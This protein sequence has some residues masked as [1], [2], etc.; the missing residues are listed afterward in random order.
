MDKQ[1]FNEG[2]KLLK[3]FLKDEGL[4]KPIYKS[5]LFKDGFRKKED[6][7]NEFN[8]DKFDDVDDWKVLFSRMNLQGYFCDIHNKYYIKYK[9]IV[10]QYNLIYKWPQYYRKHIKDGQENI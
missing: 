1:T 5:Y 3:R 4:Y 10:E 8:T 2:L 6:L 7:F 9:H